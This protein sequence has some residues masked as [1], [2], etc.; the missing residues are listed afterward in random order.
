MLTRCKNDVR[1]RHEY[2]KMQLHF[3][4]LATTVFHITAQLTQVIPV[5][6]LVK[7]YL[8]AEGWPLIIWEATTA[9]RNYYRTN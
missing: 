1:V 4:E 8:G 7:K 9:K 6:V 3:V 5:A 2:G